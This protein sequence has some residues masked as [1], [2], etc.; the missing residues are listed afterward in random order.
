MVLLGLL[1]SLRTG[2]LLAYILQEVLRDNPGNCVLIVSV[3]WHSDHSRHV[4]DGE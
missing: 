2:G 1:S 3:A 4:I